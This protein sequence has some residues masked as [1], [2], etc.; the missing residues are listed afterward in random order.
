MKLFFAK[1]TLASF[2]ITCTFNVMSAEI[3]Q[4]QIEQFK[5]LSPS[6]QQALA[7]S[8]GVDLSPLML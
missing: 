8:M 3:S 4:A 6:Q 2:F 1:L 7:S 5:Q